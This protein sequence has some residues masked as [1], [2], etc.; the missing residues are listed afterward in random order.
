MAQSSTFA[1]LDTKIALLEAGARGEI[2]LEAAE[3]DRIIDILAP[4]V[5]QAELAAREEIAE[6]QAE[7]ETARAAWETERSI[8][9]KQRELAERGRARA[10]Q[11]SAKQEVAGLVGSVQPNPFENP[12]G[13]YV[14]YLWSD[15]GELLYVGRSTNVLSRLGVHMTTPDRRREIARVATVEHPDA[16]SM[17]RAEER[18]IK[19]HR[20]PW[21]VVGVPLASA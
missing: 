10:E 15:A 5:A 2:R 9:I 8:L 7:F 18:A 4:V 21:N 20:P 17:K 13:F 14:Y 11:E 1:R 19:A 16:A 6:R 3:L 12:H